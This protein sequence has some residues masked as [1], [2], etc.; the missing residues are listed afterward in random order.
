M[1]E[2]EINRRVEYVTSLVDE[3]T[4]QKAESRIGTQVTVM[5]ESDDDGY[6]GRADFQGPEV[7]GTC[8]L[9]TDR[10]LEIGEFVTGVVV[11]NDGADLIVEEIIN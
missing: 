4:N 1:S 6:E 11:S 2:A 3:V 8:T 10:T 7:D 5:I 9:L